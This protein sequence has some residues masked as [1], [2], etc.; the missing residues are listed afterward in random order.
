MTR[1]LVI[2]YG[3]GVD[4][5]AMLFGY[6]EL[7][8]RPDAIVFADTGSEHPRTYRWIAQGLP[9]LLAELG[10]PALT[11]VRYRPE[12][13]RNGEY[14]TLEEQCLVNRTLPSRAFGM[15]KC[16]AAWKGEPIDSWVARR[17]AG[18]IAAGGVV[19]RAIGYEANE[20][21][22]CGGYRPAGAPHWN[23]IYPLR[24]WGWTRERCEE[25]LAARGLDVGKSACFFCPAS[26]PA[27]VLELAREHP[28][29]A[30]RAVAI[31]DAGRPWA[32]KVVG[33]WRRPCKGTRGATPHDGTWRG[34]LEE[35]D[36]LP[37]EALIWRYRTRLDSKKPM[38]PE[39]AL[40]SA[41]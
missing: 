29:L 35:H 22:R 5:T 6:A 36:L 21:R 4:S 9:A 14:S 1:P 3:A 38:T 15:G 31:E 32:R 34:Y 16:S 10:F 19:D 26:R 33:L 39:E 27:E 37:P 28:E 24:D 30:A 12:R 25:E 17:F 13:P 40:D 20:E 8:R 7:G 2:S 41:A 11:V 23:W 18:Y